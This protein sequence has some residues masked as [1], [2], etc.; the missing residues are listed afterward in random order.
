MSLE[1]IENII[2]KLREFSSML[3]LICDVLNITKFDTDSED[4][5]DSI[6]YVESEISMMWYQIRNLQMELNIIV[7][8]SIPSFKWN[9]N[10]DSFV[11]FTNNHK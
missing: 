10:S 3:D 7:D 11:E 2:R 9:N 8:D 1:N 5:V 6:K 4:S